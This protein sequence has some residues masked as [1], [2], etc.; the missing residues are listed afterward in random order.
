MGTSEPDSHNWIVGAPQKK[1][2]VEEQEE[3]DA[4]SFDAS[5]TLAW[6]AEPDGKGHGKG[7]AEMVEQEQQ[8]VQQLG[9]TSR[10]WD[11]GDESPMQ[12]AWASLSATER[13]AAESLGYKD[14]DFQPLQRFELADEEGDAPETESPQDSLTTGPH[15]SLGP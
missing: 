13:R 7:W 2:E 11:D 1:E 8:A 3:D 15:K 14:K 9:W 5:F 6:K 12:K 10:S 4:D